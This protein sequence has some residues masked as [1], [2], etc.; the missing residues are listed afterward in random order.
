[1]EAA[2]DNPKL[3]TEDELAEIRAG[4]KEGIRGPVVLMWVRWLLDEHDELVRFESGAGAS[5]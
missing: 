2:V 1:V 4:V 3:L 5:D